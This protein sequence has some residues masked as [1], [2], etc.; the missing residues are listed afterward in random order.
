VEG[1]D[2]EVIPV[3]VAEYAL[4]TTERP[5]R[6]SG[7]GSCGVVVLYDPREAIGGLLHF[8]LPRAA[9]R[10]DRDP[11]GKFADSGLEAMIEEFEAKGGNTNRAWAKVAGGAKMLE[12]NSF[13]RPIGE[14]NVEAAET[15]L[16]KRQIPIRG[17]DVGGSS[18]RTVTFYPASGEL[19]IK[20]ANG[21]TRTR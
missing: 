2:Y 13:D 19:S 20:T 12:F 4:S 17:S 21:E 8:M 1:N 7:V 3:G 15:I 16:E 18:G 9:S 11:V 14:R 5:L 10:A 6:T